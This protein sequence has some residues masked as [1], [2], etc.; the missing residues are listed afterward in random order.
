MTAADYVLYAVPEVWLLQRGALKI[1]PLQ[2]RIYQEQSRYF[3]QV[4]LSG[5]VG[6][7]LSV[8]AEQGTGVALRQLGQY[9]LN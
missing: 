1:Y 4:D 6:Q 7:V 9:R 3:P 2:G 8:A 5:L